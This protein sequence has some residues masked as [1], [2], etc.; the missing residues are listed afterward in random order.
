MLMKQ[1]IHYVPANDGV[2]LAWAEI[3]RGPG[4]VKAATWL[5]HLQ[6]DVDSPIWS[7]WVR[8]FGEHF[9]YVRYDERGCGMSDWQAGDLAQQHWVDDLENV[10]DAAGLAAP[11]ALLGISQGAATSIRYAVR[12]PERVS[13]LILYGGSAVGGNR[14]DDPERR[15]LFN[16]VKIGRA[17]VR[18]PVNNSHPG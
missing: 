9:R 8:F 14:S 16:A 4:L 6:D 7:H 17:H 5:T 12:H 11:F 2:R 10:V 1:R 3:G 13:H 18:T 15:A